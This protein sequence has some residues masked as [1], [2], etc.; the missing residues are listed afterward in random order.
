MKVI[1]KKEKEK[2]LK[3]WEIFNGFERKFFVG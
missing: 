1:W 2:R 3:V